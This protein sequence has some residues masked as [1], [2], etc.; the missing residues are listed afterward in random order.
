[1]EI[2][3]H[4]SE[5][6]IDEMPELEFDEAKDKG[7]GVRFVERRVARP[8]AVKWRKN[9]DGAPI[10]RVKK[11]I[12]RVEED[13]RPEPRRMSYKE[14]AVGE[15]LTEASIREILE[16]EE[17]KDN[18]EMEVI[19]DKMYEQN[20]VIGEG[21]EEELDEIKKAVKNTFQTEEMYTE[22]LEILNDGKLPSWFW[23][24]D[25]K[26]EEFRTL[27]DQKQRLS[28]L[29]LYLASV[30]GPHSTWGPYASHYSFLEDTKE[31]V[32]EI[33]EYKISLSLKKYTDFNSLF[34][35][36]E[37]AQEK[38]YIEMES[39]IP[40]I[41]PWVKI[42]ELVRIIIKIF[43]AG[44]K[45]LYK[46]VAKIIHE[47][48]G[49]HRRKINKEKYKTKMLNN[50]VYKFFLDDISRIVQALIQTNPTFASLAEKVTM[51][52]QV[53]DMLENAE[54]K[55][56]N[57]A[58]Y[59]TIAALTNLNGQI[60]NG[61]QDS[62]TITEFGHSK[63]HLSLRFKREANFSV[64]FTQEL[65]T[66]LLVLI[67]KLTSTEFSS[68]WFNQH[69]FK[70]FFDT[71][72]KIKYYL[73]T[74]KVLPI[75]SQRFHSFILFFKEETIKNLLKFVRIP[76]ETYK[77]VRVI[78]E[79]KKIWET[80]TRYLPRK[81][82]SI[83][84]Q[85]NF[86]EKFTY[87]M[88][89]ENILNSLRELDYE[90]EDES[91]LENFSF[92]ELI[93]NISTKSDLM[94]I[95][96]SST[97]LLGMGKCNRWLSLL[98]NTKQL[99]NE[100]EEIAF[101]I[102]NKRKDMLSKQKRMDIRTKKY[103]KEFFNQEV[104]YY[105]ERNFPC[106]YFVTYCLWL[107]FVDTDGMTIADVSKSTF[108]VEEYRDKYI[109]FLK[110]HPRIID[111]CA[112]GQFIFWYAYMREI[113][114][115]HP[116]LFINN[117]H[118]RFIQGTR[119]DFKNNKH[120]FQYAKNHV[121]C[122]LGTEWTE[123][124]Y[125]AKKYVLGEK[126]NK[127]IDTKEKKNVDDEMEEEF[128]D[129]VDKVLKYTNMRVGIDIESHSENGVQ[130]PYLICCTTDNVREE[131]TQFFDSVVVKDR[132]VQGKIFWGS[133][134]LA[135]FE[136]W[137]LTINNCEAKGDIT[138]ISFNGS[139]YDY[140]LV[141]KNLVTR[142]DA[143][144]FGS[145]SNYKLVSI[146]RIKFIDFLLLSP[147]GSLKNQSK[148]W[149]KDDEWFRK[150][151]LDIGG[152][153]S[154]WFEANKQQIITYCL[155][156]TIIVPRLHEEFF[157]RFYEL[158][159]KIDI[160]ELISK[161]TIA[162]LALTAFGSMLEGDEKIVG[163]SRVDIYD[164][165]RASYF[166][167]ICYNTKKY[168]TDLEYYDINS[169]YPNAMRCPLPLSLLDVGDDIVEFED[170]YEGA[171][172][173]FKQGVLYLVSFEYK[174][175]VN[176]CMTPERTESR[177]LIYPRCIVKNWRWGD[178]ILFL[179]SYSKI[180]RI[181]SWAYMVYKLKDFGREYID[182]MYNEKNKAG[183]EKNEA[184]KTLYKLLLN[185]VYGKFGQRK[186]HSFII[187][188]AIDAGPY[189]WG[190][191]ESIHKIRKLEL[192]DGSLFFQI[193][194]FEDNMNFV[195][196][197]VR[198]ASYITMKAR[199][200]LFSGVYGVGEEN[201]MYMD[202]DSIICKKKPNNA[203]KINVGDKLGEWKVE[204]GNIAK[205]YS[206]GPKMY[207]LEIP[208]GDGTF[209]SVDKI[210]GVSKGLL[211][212]KEMIETDEMVTPSHT[213]FKRSYGQIVVEECVK[214]ITRTDAK[215]RWNGNESR[216]FNST[217]DYEEYIIATRNK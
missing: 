2:Q 180:Q 178:E 128:D 49:P 156:D 17:V 5:S 116:P 84:E 37:K 213:L 157:K 149:L 138:F 60:I 144:I 53:I 193:F 83:E 169:S 36:I 3:E 200:N 12:V 30:Y 216:P 112:G 120:I 8:W 111:F 139:R 165:E 69:L 195:G 137:V 41:L 71:R 97:A 136:E 217:A 44:I 161:P 102:F 181:K 110:K 104:V 206:W 150:I 15:G 6:S 160:D 121:S 32:E 10:K 113:L 86:F 214:K 166:G 203:T 47:A 100:R 212:M 78:K 59:L 211:G 192:Q 46:K 20:L 94:S 179:L 191:D 65:V 88:S 95:V 143:R 52:T 209:K 186:F 174:E 108:I 189:I 198:L 204:E 187:K 184:K 114:N 158:G 91:F 129:P 162:S 82:S 146:G 72:T 80:L 34:S 109:E 208:I 155:M 133:D 101:D 90:G 188:K 73:V 4:K 127:G 99:K 141:L 199:I 210:K 182:V 29:F 126:K 92:T 154:L 55:F 183:V 51:E 66:F 148:L 140:I 68:S 196:S 57:G 50:D 93:I 35:A 77:E 63:G 62:K 67:R 115:I 28:N 124:E 81:N 39:K 31:K 61:Q 89:L 56:M 26:N 170:D 125:K 185:S 107:E 103:N 132:V 42:P 48:K 171:S 177:G 11:E 27:V 58:K 122:V 202:T 131:F 54:K 159:F 75:H 96:S 105:T 23:L 87:E 33:L 151:D 190:Q 135:I 38:M 76:S 79:T 207:R 201:V 64:D 16:G 118:K 172:K 175:D 123:R 106:L 43:G 145:I 163:E 9:M 142:T 205:A 98:E 85:K 168:D 215:R 197:L 22:I 134:C 21:N 25:G 167:G 7:D 153:S 40:G 14:W 1:M 19:A 117:P 173:Y 45:F 152:K 164:K 74:I 119:E 24:D 176:L 147:I 13:Y 70:I 194:F 18:G 130:V